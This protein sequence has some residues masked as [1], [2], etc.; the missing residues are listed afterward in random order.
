[1][2]IN[3]NSKPLLTFEQFCDKLKKDGAY[4]G[5]DWHIYRADGRPLSRK[6]RNGYYMLRKMYEH[7]AYYFCE[8]RVIWYFCNGAFD[9][10]LQINHKDFDRTNNNIENLELITAKENSQYTRNAGRANT[11][12][13]EDSGKAL[14]TNKEV[15]AIRYLHKNGWDKNA[16]K[17]MFDIDWSVTLNR[18]ITGTRYGSVPDAA[19]VISIY[20]AIV[21]R[22]WRSDLCKKDRITNALLGLNGEVGELTD[23]FKKSLYH[24][25][26]TDMVSVALEL[27]DVLYY[28]CALCCELGIDFAELCYENAEKLA[29]RYPEGFEAEKSL[30][31]AAGDI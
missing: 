21:Q 24:G 3:E 18:I 23:A 16:I 10:S 13:A 31:R 9:T 25:H 27:G 28:I 1:M 11:P 8:H 14:F 7:H 2:T 12:K 17:S 15:Q 19:D 26:E 29:A 4:I 6:S 22:T 20:P 5:A 30:H